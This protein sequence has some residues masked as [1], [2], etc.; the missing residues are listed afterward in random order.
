MLCARVTRGAPTRYP[1]ATRLR[2]FLRNIDV[3]LAALAPRGEDRG[4]QP[5]RLL[6]LLSRY[7]TVE[8]DRA[9]AAALTRALRERRL[10]STSYGTE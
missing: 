7:G 2:S 10:L 8:P 9:S 5:G 3:H 4:G 1:T 6:Q